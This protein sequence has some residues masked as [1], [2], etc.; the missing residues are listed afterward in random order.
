MTF[1]ERK[2]G[3][4]G[5]PHAGTP[6]PAI[7]A[8]NPVTEEPSSHWAEA[9]QWTWRAPAGSPHAHSPWGGLSIGQRDR[10]TAHS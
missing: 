1:H 10:R 3:E 6:G 2:G 9:G 5:Q 8:A 4:E 7:L